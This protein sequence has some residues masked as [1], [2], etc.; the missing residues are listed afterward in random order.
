VFVGAPPARLADL[1]DERGPGRAFRAVA[2]GTALGARLA[3]A[4]RVGGLRHVRGLP[5]YLRQS[6]G[7][8]WA[9][10]GDAGYWK[11]PLS[12]HGMTDAFRDAEFLAR[13]VLAA[14]DPGAAQH[15]ALAEYESVRDRLALPLLD[16][17][18]RLASYEWE[19]SEIRRLLMRLASVMTDEFELLATI[20]EAA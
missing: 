6:S 19:L 3:G 10:V 13:A 17:T 16:V 15:E 1:V 18:E 11:D 14:P 9:L 12:T 2:D 4:G 7:P 20:S 5:G 8:G